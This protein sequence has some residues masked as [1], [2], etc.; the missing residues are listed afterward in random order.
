M[1][2]AE[3]SETTTHAAEESAELFGG[4]RRRAFFVATVGI[5]LLALNHAFALLIE[6]V[7]LEL[8]VLGAICLTV[9]ACGIV[10][11]GA[12]GPAHNPDRTLWEGIKQ[13]PWWANLTGGA[14]TVLGLALGLWLFF[15]FYGAR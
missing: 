15:G 3:D 8:T 6:R 11:P 7:S 13:T 14:A 10:V 9:G 1:T 2:R 12:V 5:G 4:P